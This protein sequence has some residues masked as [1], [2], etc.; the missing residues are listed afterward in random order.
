MCNLEN[1]IPKKIH[2]CWFGGKDK[3]EFILECIKTWKDKMPDYELIEW[4]ESNYNINKNSFV[5]KAYENKRWAFVSDY[6]RLDVLSQH[7]GIYL[8]TDVEVLRPLDEFLSHNFFAGF[9]K[10]IIKD[11]YL[12]STAMIASVKN[13]EIITNF[14]D[15]YDSLSE[16]EFINFKTPNTK[17]LT[18]LL[19]KDFNLSSNNKF[20]DLSNSIFIYPKD[21][22]CAKD[23]DTKRLDITK[24]TFAI[25]HFDGSWKGKRKKYVD[26]LFSKIN[27][28]SGDKAY[29]I[30]KKLKNAKN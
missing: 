25:H 5:K 23:W 17:I 4:N 9:E 3:S 30:L 20:N 21:Y 7:G 18:D 24:N 27:R 11:Q 16:E 2:Y 26:S 14:I 12:V 15:F 13:H 10:G 8:D 6:V 22:F 1:R 19:E 28:L 29:L